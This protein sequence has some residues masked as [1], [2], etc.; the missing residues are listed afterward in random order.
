MLQ[1]GLPFLIVSIAFAGT[2]VELMDAPQP[3]VDDLT[4]TDQYTF[5]TN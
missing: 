3:V 2:T 5:M 4:T 1:L